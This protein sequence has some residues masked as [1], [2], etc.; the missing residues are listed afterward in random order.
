MRETTVIE[1]TD[2]DD[3]HDLLLK[4]MKAIHMLLKYYKY[5]EEDLDKIVA[6]HREKMVEN[7]T[8][9]DVYYNFPKDANKS[10]LEAFAY[11]EIAYTEINEVS[12]AVDK[13]MGWDE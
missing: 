6:A 8:I 5:T 10:L 3:G 12:V 11:C 2:D 4:S 7:G 13:E 9:A 1:Y